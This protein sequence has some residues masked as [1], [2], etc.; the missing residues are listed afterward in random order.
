L[1]ERGRQVDG[2]IKLTLLIVRSSMA[3][4]D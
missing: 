3:T 4:G 2:A 1:A